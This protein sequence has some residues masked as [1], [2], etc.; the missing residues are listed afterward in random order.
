M[1][2]SPFSSLVIAASLLAVTSSCVSGAEL[3]ARRKFAFDL[4]GAYS[5]QRGDAQ[6]PG[7][8]QIDNKSDKTDVKLTFA[9]TVLYAGESDILAHLAS[10]DDATAI[11]KGFVLGEQDDAL[12]ASLVGGTNISDDFGA[13]SKLAVATK[14]FTAKPSVTGATDSVVDYTFDIAIQNG[15]DQLTGTLNASF[16]ETQPDASKAGATKGFHDDRTF[17]VTFTRVAGKIVS[18]SCTTCTN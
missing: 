6:T 2:H 11:R 7:S 17:N 15:S 18:E 4:S 10:A 13:S 5:E 8:L 14:S 3:E 1:R 12:V 16:H 9:R